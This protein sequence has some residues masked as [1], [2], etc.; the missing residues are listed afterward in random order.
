MPGPGSAPLALI[1][2]RA[3]QQGLNSNPGHMIDV[4]ETIDVGGFASR[5]HLYQIHR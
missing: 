4:R 1:T 5:G 3:A 2:A